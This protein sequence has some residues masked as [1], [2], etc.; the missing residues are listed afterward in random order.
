MDQ[1]TRRTVMRRLQG[2]LPIDVVVD[3]IRRRRKVLDRLR[4]QRLAGVQER[5]HEPLYE[6]LDLSDCEWSWSGLHAKVDG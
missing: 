2:P 5:T 4:P 3:V 1:P 6:T